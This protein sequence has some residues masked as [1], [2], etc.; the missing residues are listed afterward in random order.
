MNRKITDVQR[1]DGILETISDRTATVAFSSETPVERWFGYEVLGHEPNNVRLGRL[2]EGGAILLNHNSHMQVGVVEKSWIDEDRKGR[3]IIRFSQSSL[4]QEIYQDVQDGIRKHVSV[5]YVIHDYRTKRSQDEKD[6]IVATDW[7]PL[8][9]SI[10]SVPADVTIGVNRNYLEEPFMETQEK[11]EAPVVASP[12]IDIEALQKETRQQELERVRTIL[13]LGEQFHMRQ[14]SEKHVTEATPLDVFRGLLLEEIRKSPGASP[15]RLANQSVVP[16]IGMNERETREYSLCRAINAAV[17]NDWTKATLEKEASLATAKK[18]GREPKG[19][20]IPPDV[21]RR[22]FTLGTSGS[23]GGGYA[24]MDPQLLLG[25]FIQLLR[26]NMIVKQLGAKILGGLSGD[27]LIPKQ[28]G[29]AT[30]YWVAESGAPTESAQTLGQIALRPKTV[31]AFTDISRKLL[32]QSSIDVESFVRSD[33][34]QTIALAIDLAALAGTGQNNQPTGILATANI[35]S[36]TWTTAPTFANVVEM[37]TAL[38]TANIATGSLA[39]VTTP[40]LRGTLKTTPKV[41]AQATYVWNDDNQMNGY[42]AFASTQMTTGYVLFGNWSDLII[43]EWTGTDIL[44]D[45]YT[46]GTS[47]TVR[48]IALQDVDIAVRYPQSFCELHAA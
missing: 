42:P 28:T 26:N 36:K 46:G 31:G 40:S 33:I 23:P 22:D 6:T 10:V 19:F 45:P 32:I 4:G 18:L 2:N 48:V 11:Y 8:E 24:G 38:A 14:L 3:A 29:G 1:R 41:T 17:T 34:T 27:V 13:S 12:K 39:Y 21:Q 15:I 25:S 37:E 7:E 35:G 16:E 20:F 9:I 5:G 44:V 47:G 30:A 43:G